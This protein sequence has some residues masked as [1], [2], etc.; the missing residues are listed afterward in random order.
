M[1]AG[2]TLKDTES[3]TSKSSPG[4]R[5]GVRVEFSNMKRKLVAFASPPRFMSCLLL[6]SNGCGD[7]RGSEQVSFVPTAR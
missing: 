6:P 3:G 7:T 4:K 2:V 5:G 1:L